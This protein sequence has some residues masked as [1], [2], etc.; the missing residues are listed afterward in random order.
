MKIKLLRKSVTRGQGMRRRG[1]SWTESREKQVKIKYLAGDKRAGEEVQGG[2]NEDEEQIREE[3][4]ERE[5]VCDEIDEIK[6]RV[7]RLKEKEAKREE[8]KEDRGTSEKRVE[9]LKRRIMDRRRK[10]EM[11]QREDRRKNV[12]IKGMK[13]GKRR[14]A[15]EKVLCEIEAKVK[16]EVLRRVRRGKRDVGVGKKGKEVGGLH[17]SGSWW[18]SKADFDYVDSGIFQ[19]VMRKKVIREGLIM[20]VGWVFKNTRSKAR[21]AL[22]EFD[23]DRFLASIMVAY[24]NKDDMEDSGQNLNPVQGAE[25]IV[26]KTDETVAKPSAGGISSPSVKKIR[27]LESELGRAIELRKVALQLAIKKAKSRTWPEFLETLQKDL[28]KIQQELFVRVVKQS[29]KDNT[30]PGHNDFL[31][32]VHALAIRVFAEKYRQLFNSSLLRGVL[33]PAWTIAKLILL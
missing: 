29:P 3:R 30:A 1:K 4:E 18:P 19:E 8:R 6:N 27:R 26:L 16:V 13:E 23:E 2:D 22:K 15:V 7:K 24:W 12:V 31:K 10:R 14:K 5:S 32:R 21:W 11:R 20:R 28:L 33:P 9:D 25:W 17:G